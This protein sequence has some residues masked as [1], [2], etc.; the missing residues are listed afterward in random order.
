MDKQ[1]LF[2][3]RTEQEFREHALKVF[4]FQAGHCPVY[5][6]FLSALSVQWQDIKDIADI[7]FFTIEFFKLRMVL[8][9]GK[10][11][12]IVFYSSGTG[13]GFTS[14]HYV[15]DL[16]IYDASFLNAFN[17]FYG[18]V[19]QYTLLALLPSYLEREGSSLI[20]MVDKLIKQAGP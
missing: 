14:R 15:H 8:Q 17:Y 6:E 18:T 1:A 16:Q 19:Q 7:P 9:A 5:Q 4:R 20:Y 11:A 13:G 2:S 3:I 10:E 12:E